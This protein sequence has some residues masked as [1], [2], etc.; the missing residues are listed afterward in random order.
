MEK[1]IDKG[2][3]NALLALGAGSAA[4][5]TGRSWLPA[6]HA[7]GSETPPAC[8]ITPE[9][10][11]GPYFTGDALE[12]ADIRSDPSSGAVSAGIPLQL[13]LRISA[14]DNTGCKPL[15]NAIVDVWHCDASGMYSDVRDFSF[16]TLGKQFLRGYQVTDADGK[17]A[18]TT[19]YPGWYPGRAVHIHFK[20]RADIG[21]GRAKVFT[22]QLYFDDAFTDEVYKLAPYNSREQRF[23]RNDRDGIFR[24]Q[25][26]E[27]LLLQLAG[28]EK[29]YTGSLDVGVMMG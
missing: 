12:R 29:G 17:V 13:T 3:R 25:G 2:R 1:R 8:V 7:A 21:G 28:G 20:V 26:G 23:P 4:L 9:Q 22:S 11:E 27:R 15:P 18:F 19:I 6:A 24:R 5:L 10:M 14:I 16:N